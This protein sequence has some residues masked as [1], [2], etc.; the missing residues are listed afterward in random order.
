MADEI[1]TQNPKVDGES[2][3]I[4]V[5]VRGWIA[6]SLVLTVCVASLLKITVAEPLYTLVV[7]AV[8]FYLGSSSKP[9]AK[10]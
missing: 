7:M 9:T 1:I 4:N 2:Q 8:S 6:I 5:S 10:P 3:I